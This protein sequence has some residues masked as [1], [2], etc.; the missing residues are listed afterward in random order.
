MSLVELILVVFIVCMVYFATNR[1]AA[2]IQV[3]DSTFGVCREFH[4]S[5]R[6]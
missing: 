5:I 1:E 3:G 4:E 2:C 6:K